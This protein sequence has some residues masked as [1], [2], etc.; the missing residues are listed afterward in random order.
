MNAAEPL[1]PLA[2]LFLHIILFV[3]PRDSFD[4]DRNALL[5]LSRVRKDLVEQMQQCTGAFSLDLCMSARDVV[6]MSPYP[7]CHLAY[8][9]RS[10]FQAI[11]NVAARFQ[12]VGSLRIDLQRMPVGCNFVNAPQILDLV[13]HCL[14]VGRAQQLCVLNAVLEAD[15][16]AHGMRSLPP[17]AKARITYMQLGN[18][19]L[20]I[21]SRFLR[22]L[23]GMRS[24]RHLHL[25]GSKF[26]LAHSGFP[27]FSDALETL[28]VS[29]CYGL[30]P[31]M[32]RS[33]TKTLGALNWSG[34]LIADSDKP[35]FLAWIK[36]SHVR[37]LDIDNCGFHLA[38]SADF[39][40]ALERMP[41][42]RSLSIAGNYIFQD[43]V[44]W[45]VYD[46]WKQG[47]LQ[48]PFFTIHISNM[49][50]CYPDSG[51]PVMIARMPFEYMDAYLD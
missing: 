33:V 3:L 9:D 25:D 28:S 15:Q 17:D 11:K 16:F 37:S 36:D 27:R 6:M 23:A 10:H 21:N 38:D 1:P 50:T 19:G 20:A 45:W 31:T 42:L 48:A 47:R 35:A 2:E 39:Q 24:L 49:H 7:C 30:R 32:L 46:F 8:F 40:S 43:D 18:C 22:E 26:H 13:F 44:F 51:R 29:N 14:S 5:R 34:N 41:A 12:S 4:C